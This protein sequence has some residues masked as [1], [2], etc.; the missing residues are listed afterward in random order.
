MAS[1]TF[2]NDITPPIAQANKR[3]RPRFVARSTAEKVQERA[4]RLYS[5]QLEGQTTRQLVIEHSKI[6]QIS[7]TTAWEDWG[8]VKTWNTED[9]DK[10]RENMLPRLQ[11]MRVRLF[12]KAVKKGQLQ[13]AAQI[14]DSLGK[15]IGESVETVNIQAPELSIKVESKE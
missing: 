2:P 15:V 1:S 6:E 5:R 11:A 4:Q 10:D 9:W 3:G 12:N 7:I 8:K 13:T 14:L